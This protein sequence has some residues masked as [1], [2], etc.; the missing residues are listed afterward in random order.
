MAETVAETDQKIIKSKNFE[1]LNE[2]QILL[3][4]EIQ[5]EYKKGMLALNSLP[6]QTI[7]FYG[8]G[9][10]V[11]GSKSYQQTLELARELAK[12]GWGVV[13]G[14][15]P[16]IMSASL[17]GAKL[18]G[19]KAVSFRIDIAQE[20]A[21]SGSDVDIL[22]KHFSVR[23]Y[24]LRQSDAFVYA[25]GG[26]GT[27]DELMENLTLI[28]TGKHSRKP[29][30]LLDSDFWSGYVQWFEKIL[31]DERKTVSEELFKLFHVVDTTEQ[32][33]EILYAS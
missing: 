18:G 26:I 21:A 16:G 5:E 30:F 14:G 20:P 10:I 19:G 33:M 11:E 15:G 23:K 28:I 4:Q 9:R 24:V 1:T 12:K 2:W 17:E 22:F 13:S 6:S 3:L 8:G 32:V 27:L 31:F 29:I 25:P 7:T